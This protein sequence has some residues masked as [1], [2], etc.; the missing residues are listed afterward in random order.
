MS[1]K[2]EKLAQ[3]L[4]E[5]QKLVAIKVDQNEAFKTAYK[6]LED[7]ATE[8]NTEKLK[9]QIVSQ[10]QNSARALSDFFSSCDSLQSY[11]FEVS[12]L[13]SHLEQNKLEPSA[14]SL[15]L[16]VSS[17]QQQN[18]YELFATQETSIGRNPDCEIALDPDLYDKISWNH[19]KIKAISQPGTASTSVE[20]QLCDLNSTNGTYINGQRLQGCQALQP[21]DRI[22]L[23]S[24]ST[25]RSNPEFIFESQPA[26]PDTEDNNFYNQVIDCDVLCLIIDAT[27][28]LSTAEKHLITKA[29][30]SQIAKQIIVADLQSI[31][32]K[33]TELIKSNIAEIETWVKQQFVELSFE[34][35]TL[36]LHLFNSNAQNNQPS[37]E[38]QQELEK[39]RKS[40]ETLV[41]RKPEDILAQ[42]LAAKVL[43]QLALIEQVFDTEVESLNWQIQQEEDKLQQLANNDLKEQAKKVLKKAN[44]D[45]DKFFKQIKVELSQSKAALLDPYSKKSIFYSLQSFVD[46]LK[47]F[48]LKRN[49]YKY[50]QLRTEDTVTPDNINV[51][52]IRFCSSKLEQWSNVEWK[53]IRTSYA[54]GGLDGLF[55]SLYKT[56]NFIPSLTLDNSLFQSEQ[57]VELHRSIFNSFAEI[58]CESR[59]QEASL[60]GYVQK[61]LRTNMFQV[62][63]MFGLLTTLGIA[64]VNA[65]QMLSRAFKPLITTPWLF[66]IVLFIVAS[67]IAYTYQKD[68]RL[69]LEEIGEK[70]K[71]DLFNH[72]QSL[73]KNLAERLVQDFSMVL[74]T[75]ERRTRE[76]IESVN[77]K[78]TS[79]II[80]TE[81][82]QLLL[83]NNIEQQKLQQKTLDKEKIEFQKLKRL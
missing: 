21:G 58:P 26:L 33:E 77:E 74:E 35:F 76:I 73:A 47:P 36:A 63:F 9:F 24:P 31:G 66:G 34:L 12:C 25:N 81:K 32:S 55:Q 49:G 20:W 5:I 1:P 60:I 62:T 19:A 4:Q 38:L 30:T 29:S 52:L 70:L 79:Y 78:F 59:Y 41:K 22:T 61:Q 27:Q 23:A 83:K 46:N 16:Q 2:S 6:K 75:E 53:Q 13:P 7:I 8:L 18:R 43:T 17:E 11:E 72:Y 50:V 69:K 82:S 65:R 42:R 28:H 37:P 54:E 71:K 14:T 57:S 45:K 39:L 48:V 15:V 10:N 3:R 40:L 56:L 44:E 67:L 51:N 64:S 68:K 80:D